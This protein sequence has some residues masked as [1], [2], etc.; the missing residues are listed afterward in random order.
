MLGLDMFI[1]KNSSSANLLKA[2]DSKV[3]QKSI[4]SPERLRSKIH[5]SFMLNQTMAK[6]CMPNQVRKYKCNNLWP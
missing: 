4:F 5:W 2:A 3:D 6:I 1:K